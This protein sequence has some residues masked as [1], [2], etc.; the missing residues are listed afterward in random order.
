MIIKTM[1]MAIMIAA[2]SFA[3]AENEGNLIVEILSAKIQKKGVS[4]ESLVPGFYFSTNLTPMNLKNLS[5]IRAVYSEA[6]CVRKMGY[7][8]DELLARAA[9]GE[10]L[11][12]SKP[13]FQ[14][15]EQAAN[16]AEVKRIL[17]VILE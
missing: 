2:C 13:P 4:C 1:L 5:L 8:L 12:R 16:T 14:I 9:S 7:E 11:R 10:G 15:D 6:G 3:N 17:K